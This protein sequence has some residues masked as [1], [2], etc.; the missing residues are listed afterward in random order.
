MGRDRLLK[1]RHKIDPVPWSRIE[2]EID[3]N[4]SA[5]EEL[6]QRHREIVA[7]INK[8]TEDL[9]VLLCPT[10]PYSPCPVSEV[11]SDADAIEWN[12]LVGRNT[13]PVNLFGQCGISLPVHKAGELPV[14]LQLQCR[15]G[16]DDRLLA[17]AASVERILGR[18]PEPDVSAFVNHR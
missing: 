11:S 1:D 4:E 9:D 8:K 12:R 6:R 13:R 5:L 15:S 14:G 7:T 18:G 16:G 10:V 2:S 17:C 3:I